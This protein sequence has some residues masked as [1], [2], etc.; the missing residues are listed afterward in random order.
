M[1][2]KNIMQ[3]VPGWLLE[4]LRDVALWPFNLMRDL[5]SR[6]MRLLMAI[7][8]ALVGIVLFVPRVLQA[9]R[10]SNFAKW[11][12]GR[13]LAAALWPLTL[14][15]ALLDLIGFPEVVQFIWHV[16]SRSR[17]LSTEESNVAQWALGEGAIR[18]GDIRVCEG[19]FLGL[20][21]KLN[22]RR[23]FATFHTINLCEGRDDAATVVHELVHVLQ[24]EKLGSV[25]IVQA[26]RAQIAMGKAA[27]QY[28]K[29]AGLR[30]ERTAG[31]RFADCNREQQAQIVED[32]VRFCR[33][34]DTE[35]PDCSAYE[36]FIADMRAGLL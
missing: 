19:G 5:L 18:Y 16:F 29:A 13:V 35:Y 32:F 26:L 11:L 36:P 1:T 27:Y 7:W 25:Y 22:K 10:E 2:A 31:H 6:V 8:G 34:E 20:I 33:D 24:F 9:S 23:P 14:L 21:F 17:P 4:R 30:R 3:A 12:R 28:G 15:L